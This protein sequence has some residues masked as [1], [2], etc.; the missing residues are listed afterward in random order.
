MNRSGLH[1]LK[2]Y[3]VVQGIDVQGLA[4]SIGHTSDCRAAVDG[5]MCVVLEGYRLACAVNC[6]YLELTIR[7]L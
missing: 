3:E 5:A 2:D 7:V 6:L 1:T 4:K